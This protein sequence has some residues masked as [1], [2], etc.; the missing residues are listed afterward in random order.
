MRTKQTQAIDP[1][2]ILNQGLAYAGVGLIG[3]AFHYAVMIMLL[4]AEFAQL[5]FASTTGAIAGGFINYVLSHR[6]VF[7]S[8]VKH[9]TALLR[10]TTVAVIGFGL[11][12]V[13]LVLCAPVF[14]APVGQA[15]ATAAVLV[16]G[17]VLNRS[18]SFRD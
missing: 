13:V 15:T 12:A 7:H 9:S 18:W 8:R 4:Q 10:F 5:V 17:F 14:G 3:T 16:C 2:R 6:R 11:N 1:L